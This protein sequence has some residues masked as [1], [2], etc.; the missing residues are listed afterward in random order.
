M[1]HVP[2][3]NDQNNK[4]CLGQTCQLLFCMSSVIA[5][6]YGHVYFIVSHGGVMSIT[7]EVIIGV[8][9]N[10]TCIDFV[11]ML[12]SLKKIGKFVPYK[13]LYFIYITRIS[14]QS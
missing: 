13:Y 3:G 9:P 14:F 10:C 6:G 7:C 4:C 1:H 5:P 11:S 8:I 12:T 2:I